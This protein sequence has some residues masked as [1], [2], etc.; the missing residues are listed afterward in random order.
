VKHLSFCINV[1][2]AFGVVYCKNEHFEPCACCCVW[3]ITSFLVFYDF[4]ELTSGF[5]SCTTAYYGQVFERFLFDLQRVLFIT[6][7]F[8]TAC[9]ADQF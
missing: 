1:Q 4:V 7:S 6:F 9:I 5:L 2:S 8:S 3:L